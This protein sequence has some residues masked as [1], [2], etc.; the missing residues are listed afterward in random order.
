MI[1]P[2]MINGYP[3]KKYSDK[4]IEKCKQKIDFIKNKLIDAN[5]MDI[6]YRI[7]INDILKD[8]ETK[9]YEMEHAIKWISYNEIIY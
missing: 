3:V 7:M 1:D 8:Y 9:L 4:Q 2:K 6:E 5:I